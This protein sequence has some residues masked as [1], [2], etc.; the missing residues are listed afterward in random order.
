MVTPID[1]FRSKVCESY[2][3]EFIILFGTRAPE[4]CMLDNG[5]DLAIV[6]NGFRG[7]FWATQSAMAD[8]AYHILLETSVRIDPWPIWVDE[9]INSETSPNCWLIETIKHECCMIL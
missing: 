4:M 3:V 8:I 5:W 6:L 7:D 9:W 2:D 1:M